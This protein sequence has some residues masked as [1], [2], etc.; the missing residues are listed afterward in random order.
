MK[1]AI[2][3]LFLALS[4]PVAAQQRCE[5]TVRNGQTF[6]QC[7]EASTGKRTLCLWEGG[8]WSCSIMN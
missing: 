6:M 4:A 5:Q 3:V 2:A 8:G 7:Y 1:F